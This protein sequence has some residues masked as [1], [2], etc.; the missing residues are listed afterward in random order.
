MENRAVTVGCAYCGEPI[1]ATR[2]EGSAHCCE[3]CAFIDRLQASA[4]PLPPSIRTVETILQVEGVTCS[5]CVARV[6]SALGAVAGVSEARLNPA[7]RRA[8][9][10]HDERLALDALVNALGK[11]GYRAR[12]AQDPAE[13]EREERRR[14]LWRL[15]LAGFAMMQI[16]MFAFPAYV[17]DDGS[18]PWDIERLF[19]LASLALI[20]PVL[21]ISARPIFAAAWRGAV[22]R[23]PGMDLP[24]ALGILVSFAASLAHTF[25]GGEVYYDSIAMFVFFLLAAR[26]LERAA[27]SRA[28]DATDALSQL[29][30]RRARRVT[31]AGFEEIDCHVLRVGDR[32]AIAVGEA[33]PADCLLVEGTTHFDEAL[34]TGE[35]A[36]VVKRH[37]DTLL[38]G[39]VNLSSPIE[40]RV[41]RAGADQTLE[42]IRSLVERAAGERP[43]WTLIADRIAGHFAVAVVALAATGAFAW[44]FVDPSRALWVAIA[45]L[46]VSC[47]CALAL[48]TPAAITAAVHRLARRGVLVTRGRALE[49]LAS[50]TH[51]VFDKTGTLTTGRMRL[52][53]VETFGRMSRERCLALAAALEAALPHPIAHAIAGAA[54]GPRAPAINMKV[55]PGEGVEGEVG[56]NRYRVGNGRF[57]ETV[58]GSPAPTVGD[59]SAPGAFLASAEGWLAAFRLED[60]LRPE[61]AELVR[62]LR[63]AGCEIV[64]LS[65]DR[66]SV[67][68][69]IAA[70]LGIRERIADADPRTKSLF[71]SRLMATGARVA[72]VGDG[73]NDAPVLASAHVAM[74]PA[75]GTAIAQSQADF[76]LANPSLLSIVE[77]LDTARRTRAIV[78]QNLAWAAAYNAAAIPLALAGVLTPWIASLGMSLSSLF[79]VLNALRLSGTRLPPSASRALIPDP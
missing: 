8:R 28:A 59:D 34:V 55:F 66:R 44:S 10:V 36:P 77:A 7:T 49:S 58:A 32:V 37:G 20:L 11:A 73:V 31:A 70:A 4:A 25:N 13:W 26:H 75:S 74:T 57:C 53:A 33:A 5:A 30:P 21:A 14:S 6:G 40:A 23:E 24:V 1:P 50:V 60:A 61:S 15:A 29:L 54:P 52:A 46:V 19:A 3:G 69:P 2:P 45:T 38:A 17:A 43:Y 51:V 12:A 42:R 41:T 72:M 67:V 16:M 63:E 62:Q 47:P 68:E 9:V 71:V 27:L 79:V 35:S 48:A 76:I 22:A 39:T 78:K 18:L 64:L 56:G 65:G